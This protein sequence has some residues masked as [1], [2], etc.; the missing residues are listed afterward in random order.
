MR[1]PLEVLAEVLEDHAGTRLGDELDSVRQHYT[2][3]RAVAALTVSTAD[4]HTG[5][6]DAARLEPLGPGWENFDAMGDAISSAMRLKLDKDAIGRLH[7]TAKIARLT[8]DAGACSM[9]KD[10]VDS[11]VDLIG[12]PGNCA[13]CGRIWSHTTAKE[14]R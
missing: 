9:C 10:R 7:N 4:K 14:K 2:H 12:Q 13:E 6:R 8:L 1:D 5:G 3:L 11:G